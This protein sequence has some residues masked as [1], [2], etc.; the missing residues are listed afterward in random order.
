LSSFDVS[1][2]FQEEDNPRRPAKKKAASNDG[3]DGTPAIPGNGGSDGKPPDFGDKI[4][5][6][7]MEGAR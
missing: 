6:L 3:K 4:L 2:T 1:S 5:V 7:F